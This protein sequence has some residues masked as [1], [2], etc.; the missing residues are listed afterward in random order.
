MVSIVRSAVEVAEFH[1]HIEQRKARIEH[2]MQLGMGTQSAENQLEELK[3]TLAH[4][5]YHQSVLAV[6]LA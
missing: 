6:S 2:L 3:S 5:Q 4:L 1:H